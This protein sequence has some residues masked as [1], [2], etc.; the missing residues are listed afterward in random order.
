MWRPVRD[1][2]KVHLHA[3]TRKGAAALNPAFAGRDYLDKDELPE[4]LRELEPYQI[5]DFLC[6]FKGRLGSWSGEDSGELRG[7]VTGKDGDESP[8]PCAPTISRAGVC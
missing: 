7:C 6:I 4:P 3:G 2:P 8:I 5:E 1:Q